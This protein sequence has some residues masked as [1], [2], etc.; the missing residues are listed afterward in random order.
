MTVNMLRI[1]VETMVNGVDFL[2]IFM[3][4]LLIFYIAAQEFK[5]KQAD[6]TDYHG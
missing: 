5:L 4:S 2:F 6:D 3:P 1:T